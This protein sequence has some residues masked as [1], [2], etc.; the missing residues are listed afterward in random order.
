MVLAARGKITRIY[1]DPIQCYI[2]LDTQNPR[3]KDGYYKLLLSHANYNAIYSLCLS[4]AIN[5]ME[6]KIRAESD[7]ISSE[8][9]EVNYATVDY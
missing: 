2:Q 5:D 3:P 6:V 9:A 4:A 1:P 7:I 8:H